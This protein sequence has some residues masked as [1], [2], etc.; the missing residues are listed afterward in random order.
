MDRQLH[1]LPGKGSVSSS[2][3][4][5]GY[6]LKNHIGFNESSIFAHRTQENLPYAN[7][8][9]LSANNDLAVSERKNFNPPFS[10]FPDAHLRRP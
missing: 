1:K 3:A 8:E 4:E 5:L 9:R 10:S 7:F 2:Q 6:G